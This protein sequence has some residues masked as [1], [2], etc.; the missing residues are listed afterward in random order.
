MLKGHSSQQ[1]VYESIHRDLLMAFGTWGFDPMELENP[2]LNNEGSVHIWHG[3]E[4]GFVPVALQ[5][6]IAQ[7]LPWIHYHEI[8]GAGHLF[9]VVPGM[10]DAIVKSLLTGEK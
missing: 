2:F 1:G 8:P 3:D 4:D 6:Y 10:S 9:P 5:R 7:R